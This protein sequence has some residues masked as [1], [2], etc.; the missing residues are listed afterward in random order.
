MA[1]TFVRGFVALAVCA[2]TVGGTTV[3]GTAQ[4]PDVI[5]MDGKTYPLTA[6]PLEAYF[7]KYP[8]RR[9]SGTVTSTANWR[10]Y[11]AHFAV[12]ERRLMVTDVLASSP[13]GERSAMKEVFKAGGPVHADWVRGHLTVPDGKLVNY[14]HM[15]YASEY[16]RYI[17]LRVEGGVVTKR[18]RLGLEAFTQFRRAQFAAFKQTPAYRDAVQ[19][20]GRAADGMSPAMLD[21]FLFEF[22]SPVYVAMLF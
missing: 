14:V 19:D 3:D 15:G 6:N 4:Q 2:L 11:V 21:Q 9:P 20:A 1:G 5:V 22:L 16:D 12:V 17:V 8:D 10:G 13:Q 18:E 7:E